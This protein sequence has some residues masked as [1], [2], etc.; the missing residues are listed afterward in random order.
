MCFPK[1]VLNVNSEILKIIIM[2]TNSVYDLTFA[3]S[4][5]KFPI[6]I[7]SHPVESVRYV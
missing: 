5:A 1:C 7:D 3:D 2:G 6:I 4:A